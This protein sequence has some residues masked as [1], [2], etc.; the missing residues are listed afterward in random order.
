MHKIVNPQQT[1][2][3][4]PFDSILTEKTRKRLLDGWP[5]VFR[6]VILEL[7]PVD[8][9][10]G[11]FDPA[12]GRPTK[13]LYSMAGL[14]LIMEF[15]NWTK[16]E[17]LDAYRFHLDIQYALNLEPVAHDISIR[18]LERYI[19]DFEEDNL[20]KTIMSDITV[21]LVDLLGIKID[22]QRLDS[23]H[24]FSDMASFGRTRMMG[25]TIKRFLT[26]VKRRNPED[27]HALPEPLRQRYLPGVHQLFGNTDKDSESRRLL[28][29]QV[30]ED[31]YYLV[32]HFAELPDYAGI[33][34]YKIMER[35]FYE[36]CEVH[37]DK[38]SVKPKTGGNVTQNPSDPDAT[39]DGHK[40]PGYQ[41]QIAETCN[42]E[43]EAQLITC[44]IPQTAAEPD[45]GSV[46]KV[47]GD[48]GN[49]NLLP[50]QMLADTH[51]TGDENV[52]LAEE[53]GVELVGPVPSGSGKNRDDDKDEYE[54][55]SVDDFDI[56]EQSEEVVCCPAGHAPQ[57]SE[58]NNETGK[59]KTVMPESACGQCE[60]FAQCPVEKIKGQ[61][62]FEHTAKQ[63][64]LAGRRR[65][66]D[67]EVFRERYKTR[68][69]IEATNSGLKRKTGLGQLRVRGRPA[70]FHAIYLKI[71]GWNIVRASVCVKIRQ[72]VYARANM[73]V[74]WFNFAFLRI[75]IAAESVR[76]GV[77]RRFLLHCRKFEKFSKLSIAA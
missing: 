19:N 47:L 20:A 10:A 31:M 2:L 76:M 43:N 25:V 55:L 3:F 62:K 42:P 22:E 13:E 16:E 64:R 72:I 23:T 59:T 37:E 30:A 46:E 18:T 66:Q 70:V 28:R 39:Y 17:A 75:T 11:Q 77:N 21:E 71:A 35:I 14:L 5:G 53:K 54:R 63:R 52:Q 65:E 15:K 26:Q 9:I 73:A 38:V 8:I 57:S 51:Y 24:I 49:N 58:H 60:F 48:L 12:M 67:T 34:T 4:D 41:V 32:R 56:D 27:Y 69:G 44:A 61:Y 45:G 6:H 68:G 50:D 36:Q 33:N 1:R 40:G 74:F 7:M 29:Q